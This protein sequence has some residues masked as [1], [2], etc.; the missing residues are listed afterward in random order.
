M[1]RAKNAT[2]L[3]QKLARIIAAAR[4]EA[5]SILC[6]ATDPCGGFVPEWGESSNNGENGERDV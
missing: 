2:P 3:S 1:V 4:K 5:F 6:V